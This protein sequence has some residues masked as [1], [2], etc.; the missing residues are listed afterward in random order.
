MNL[1]YGTFSRLGVR[2]FSGFNINCPEAFEAPN[3]VQ[4]MVRGGIGSLVFLYYFYKEPHGLGF[5][6]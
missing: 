3:F 5:R 4:Q 2:K 1:V 6:A